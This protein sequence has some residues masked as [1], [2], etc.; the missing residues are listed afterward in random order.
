MVKILYIG[1]KLTRHGFTPGVIDMLGTL[2]EK[3]G[4][5]VAYAGTYKNRF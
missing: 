3:E 1:N 2:L 4:Y 5:N